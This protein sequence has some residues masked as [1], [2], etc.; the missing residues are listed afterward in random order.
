MFALPRLTP[1]NC[2]CEAGLVAPAA[3]CTLAGETD[4]LEGSLLANAMVTPPGGAAAGSVMARP[5]DCPRLRIRFFGTPIPPRFTTEM[6]AV[7]SGIP[8][9][10]LAWMTADPTVTPVIG[11]TMVVVLPGKDA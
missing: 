3:I 1:L 11:T 4:T 8:G 10:A 6:F 9:R 7:V 2:G 5:A